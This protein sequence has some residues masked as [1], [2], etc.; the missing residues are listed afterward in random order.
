MHLLA[1]LPGR[2][3]GF[4]TFVLCPL[5][6][7]HGEFCSASAVPGAPTASRFGSRRVPGPPGGAAL[8]ARVGFVLP[9]SAN[10]RTCQPGAPSWIRGRRAS[11]S[12]PAS[13]LSLEQPEVAGSEGKGRSRVWGYGVEAGEGVRLCLSQRIA[14][15]QPGNSPAPAQS[16]SACPPARRQVRGTG[17]PR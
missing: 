8:P 17:L 12:F 11:P 3:S 9:V 2:V 13:R 1:E 7:K 5:G 14:A 6:Q 16:W 10:V 4:H 15:G